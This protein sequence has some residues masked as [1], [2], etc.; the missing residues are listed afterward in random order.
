MIENELKMLLEIEGFLR[1][2]KDALLME[3]VPHEC[4]VLAQDKKSF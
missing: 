3:V 2:D 4:R 1:Q